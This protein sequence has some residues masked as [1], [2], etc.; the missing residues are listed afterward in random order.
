MPLPSVRF[1]TFRILILTC[2]GVSFA[3]GT[4]DGLVGIFPATCVP[5]STCPRN[6][7][8]HS[9]TP[10]AAKGQAVTVALKIRRMKF[11]RPIFPRDDRFG[12]EA[13]PRCQARY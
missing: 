12:L 6:M 2:T 1:R 3:H 7:R 13:V 10:P 11:M 4:N 8:R 9:R 5:L